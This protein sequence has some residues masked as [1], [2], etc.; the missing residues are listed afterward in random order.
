MKVTMNKIAWLFLVSLPFLF[1]LQ[2]LAQEENNKKISIEVDD[3]PHIEDVYDQSPIRLSQ[4]QFRDRIMKIQSISRS[5]GIAE[6]PVNANGANVFQNK[7]FLNSSYF[8]NTFGMNSIFSHRFRRDF[9]F[10]GESGYFSTNSFLN[11]TG[12]NSSPIGQSLP[13]NASV[14]LIPLYAGV[15]KGFFLNRSSL[16]NYY[17][18]VGA[19]AGA[20]FGFGQ[21]QDF[22]NYNRS[23]EV[24]PSAYVVFG[25]E[26]YTFKKIFLDLGVRYRY[27]TFADNLALWQ[28]FSGFTFNFGF[29]Y[30][31]GMRLLR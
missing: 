23:F 25:T 9:Y 21:I 13:G 10:V 24:T 30:G 14:T 7:G 5:Q 27:L 19:G 31:F 2:L 4:K 20:V 6:S 22:N 3:Y 28:D 29:G 8:R 11:N 17:P 15:R 16:K 18:Y 26:I 12:L 1:P